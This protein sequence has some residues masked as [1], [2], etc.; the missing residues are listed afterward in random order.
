MSAQAVNMNFNMN[1]YD[2]GHTFHDANQPPAEL[3]SGGLATLGVVCSNTGSFPAGHY[4]AR[5]WSSASDNSSAAFINLA[6]HEL[7]THVQR[8]AYL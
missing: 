7:G 5:G 8:T 6:A 3:Y 2:I 1:S 4:K